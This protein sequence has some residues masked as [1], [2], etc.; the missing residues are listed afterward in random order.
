MLLLVFC[1]RLPSFVTR[2]EDPANLSIAASLNPA[3]SDF[4][5]K[6]YGLNSRDKAEY[7]NIF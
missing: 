7:I 2:L 3:T 1:I 5:V 6:A 4:L